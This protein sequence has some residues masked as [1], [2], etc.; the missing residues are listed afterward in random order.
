VTRRL[1]TPALVSRSMTRRSCTRS[2]CFTGSGGLGP[3]ALWGGQTQAFQT[4]GPLVHI[5]S[6]IDREKAFLAEIPVHPDESSVRPHRPTVAA[7]AKIRTSFGDLR[8]V[9]S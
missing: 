3:P 4:S 7:V 8:T 6:L 1:S 2:L 5:S 9:R